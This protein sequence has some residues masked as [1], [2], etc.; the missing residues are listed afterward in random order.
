V[1]ARAVREKEQGCE[2]S[3]CEP[4]CRLD[5]GELPGVETEAKKLY[6]PAS[7][8]KD[9]GHPIVDQV[10]LSAQQV[11]PS[12]KRQKGDVF[13]GSD[14]KRKRERDGSAVVGSAVVEAGTLQPSC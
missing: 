9:G 1:A 12:R 4:S 11:I 5:T 3:P 8:P 13:S 10:V 14:Q 6:L 2:P 7:Q